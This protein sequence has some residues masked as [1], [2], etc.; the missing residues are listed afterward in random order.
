MLF[1]AAIYVQNH[2]RNNNAGA[3]CLKFVFSIIIFPCAIMKHSILILLFIL[4]AGNLQAQ[5]TITFVQK[6]DIPVRTAAGT[7]QAP[8]TGGLNTP[9]FSTIDLNK[10]GVQDLF[11]FD[12]ILKKV[13]TWLAV[14]ENGV[15]KYKYDPAY[16]A[17]FP[18]SL[19]GWVLL[20]DYN[21][22]GLKDIFTSDPLGIRVYRQVTADNG[23]PAFVQSKEF[24]TYGAG[25]YNMQM[26][27]AD[28]PAI[29]DMDGDGDLDIL[30][31]EFS[32][33]QNLEYYQN[34][35]VEQGL[36]CSELK[37]V[38]NTNWW[39]NITECSGCNNYVF[40]GSCRLAG[41]VHS[42]HDGTSLLLIDLDGDGDKDLLSGGVECNELIMMENKGTALQARMESMEVVFP[43]NTRQ[44]SFHKFPAGYY[45]DVTFDNV[46]DMLITPNADHANGDSESRNSVWLYRNKGLA[47]KPDFEFVQEDFLQ[48]DM[49]DLGEGAYPAFADID[50]DGDL[51][52][53]IGNN[54]SFHDGTFKASISYYKNTGTASEPEFTFVTDDYLDIKSRNLLTI[55][56]AFADMNGDGAADLVLTYRLQQAG[57]KRVTYLPNTGGKGAAMVFNWT[58]QQTIKTL[59]D[60]DSPA[61]FDA[62]GDG[63]QDFLLGRSNGD[64]QLYLNTGTAASPNYTLSVANLGGINADFARAKLNPAIA[65]VGGDDTPD[66]IT[67]DDSGVL[68]VYINFTDKLNTTF[69][70][71]TELLVNGLTTE[72]SQTRLGR[73]LNVTPVLFG[74][75][76]NLR[77]FI[78][79]LGGGVV[80]LEQ[81]TGNINQPGQEE[82]ALKVDVYPNPAARQTHD[83]IQVNTSEPVTLVIYDALGREVFGSVAGFKHRHSI[84][85]YN[86]NGGMYFVRAI[87]KSGKSKTTKLIIL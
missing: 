18:Q 52:M 7:L 10:D 27:G 13:F 3:S 87:S 38:L 43:T 51:D 4:Y 14:Q 8:W 81:A 59:S 74:S 49:I 21:C 31:S 85:F 75:Q 11:A 6:Q 33:G 12:R 29:V 50:G 32:R 39:G 34:M 62:D 30:L 46:P 48:R 44:A 60:N 65:D 47:D 63:D 28:I 76:G 36:N 25:D 9:Q 35:R 73:G 86:L 82:M 69:T 1:L 61:F 83:A 55:K 17:L 16:E 40:G 45:E 19:H 68:K 42:G 66:L 54:G 15:W 67:V 72:V 20:R 58:N 37:F 56:P 5:S 64:L 53:L 23:L 71:D 24:L 79:S 70:A 80:M 77:L 78:G 22:D 26:T 41:P 84:R 2:K 57:T